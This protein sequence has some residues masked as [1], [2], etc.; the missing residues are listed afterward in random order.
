MVSLLGWAIRVEMGFP[1][2]LPATT[3]S[4]GEDEEEERKGGEV[5]LLAT[6]GAF[7]L[8]GGGLGVLLALLLV[9]GG[10]GWA[11]EE[12][13]DEATEGELSLCTIAQVI[14]HEDEAVPLIPP[15]DIASIATHATYRSALDIGSDVGVDLYLAYCACYPDLGERSEEGS[16]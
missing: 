4:A 10:R 14:G 11:D 16:T 6:L 7:G 1:F 13:A 12:F 15:L 2:I 9:L 3:V 8:A 5:G